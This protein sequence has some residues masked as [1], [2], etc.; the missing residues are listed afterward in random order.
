MHQVYRII[1]IITNSF[2][3]LICQRK[4]NEIN[5]ILNL[6]FCSYDIISYYFQKS[7]PRLPIPKPQKTLERY[8]R[9]QRPLLNDDQ[10]KVT[11][12]YCNK[13]MKTGELKSLKQCNLFILINLFKVGGSFKRC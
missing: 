3:F 5:E 6:I 4:F 8:L 11:E 13:F 7:L 10:Y 12:G 2:M 1:T 9:S